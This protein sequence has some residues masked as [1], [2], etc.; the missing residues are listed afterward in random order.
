[1]AT[2]QRQLK[3]LQW[4][5]LALTGAVLV[6]NARMGSGTAPPRSPAGCWPPP[7]GWAA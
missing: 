4:V 1:V 5:I 7:T 6:V 3:L 2:A